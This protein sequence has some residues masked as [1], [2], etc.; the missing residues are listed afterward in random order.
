MILR[1]DVPRSL[2]DLDEVAEEFDD[3]MVSKARQKVT[4]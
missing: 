2:E 1:H 3:W 4:G